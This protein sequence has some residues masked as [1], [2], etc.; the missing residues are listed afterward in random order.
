LRCCSNSPKIC[1]ISNPVVHYGIIA[2][3]NQVI[4]NLGGVLCF[5]MEAA[6]LMNT[7]PCLAGRRSK[8]A[9]NS[10]SHENKEWQAY[11]A[12]YIKELLARLSLLK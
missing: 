3:G 11:A 7:F 2:L 10:D 4:R 12:A 8:V 5:E 1:Q 6:G 9:R